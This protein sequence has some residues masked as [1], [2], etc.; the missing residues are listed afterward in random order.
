M[1]MLKVVLIGLGAIGKEVLGHLDAD[2]AIRVTSTLLRPAR[3]SSNRPR[4]IPS[5]IQVAS[6]VDEMEELP[7][8]ALEC[9]G[10]DAIGEHVIPLLRRGVSVGICSVGAFIEDG[11]ARDVQRAAAAGG[12]QAHLL[13]GAVGGIDALSAARLLG[14]DSVTLTSRKP[15][16]GWIGTLAEQ[17]CD[18]NALIDP[19][20]LFHGSARQA[21]RL[22]PRNANSSATVGLAG[23][24]LDKTEVTLVADPAVSSN[25]HEIYA[26][27]AFG[28][29]R[30]VTSNKPLAENPKTSALA[31]LSAVRAIRNR[32]GAVVL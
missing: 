20:V 3:L 15:P 7:D 16:M 24:G 17:V 12:A 18:L 32:A 2:P 9:A 19:F 8:F 1:A 11:L 23:V 21:A 5:G 31:A 10:P 29:M 4:E 30:F 6:S 22:F 28:E 26:R 25:T 27:G 13:A 14:L